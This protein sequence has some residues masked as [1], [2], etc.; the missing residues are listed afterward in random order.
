MG[1]Q[2]LNKSVIYFLDQYKEGHLEKQGQT[3]GQILPLLT[4]PEG[5]AQ[6]L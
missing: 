5:L 6:R 1:S 4:K 2:A 3:N